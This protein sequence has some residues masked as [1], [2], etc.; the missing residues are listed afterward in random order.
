MIAQLGDIT[1]D[2]SPAFCAFD[3]TKRVDFAE[4]ATIEGKPKLQY[5][6]DALDQARMRLR[7][8]AAFCDPEAEVKK[9]KDALAAHE[10]MP[11]MF[12]N[13]SYKGM[14]VIEEIGDELE[15][16][17]DDGKLMAADVEVKLREWVKEK[18]LT[19]RRVKGK[20]ATTSAKKKTTVTPTPWI[21]TKKEDVPKSKIV[22]Q[23]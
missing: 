16:T 1:F 9:L 2:L 6:G 11:F 15:A 23:Q 8:N 17:F 5:M 12:S 20:A 13:G 14:Y 22:R 19:A 21:G 4:H 10:A 18:A 7:F 3:A